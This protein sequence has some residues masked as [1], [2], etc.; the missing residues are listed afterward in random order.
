[1]HDQ[2]IVDPLAMAL[3]GVVRK[4]PAGER[5]TLLGVI[6]GQLRGMCGERAHP[7]GEVGDHDRDSQRQTASTC[8]VE[9]RPKRC[10]KRR[11]P[12]SGAA[13]TDMQ[14]CG[15]PHTSVALSDD[16]VLEEMRRCA[17]DL[18]DDFFHYEAYRSWALAQQV[19]NPD[20][21]TLPID[22]GDFIGRF[23]SYPRARI[24]AGL[25]RVPRRVVEDDVEGSFVACVSAIQAAADEIGRTR[26][27]STREYMQWRSAHL[28]DKERRRVLAPPP[29]WKTISDQF[30][31]WPNALAA[32]GI[33]SRREAADYYRGDGEHASDAHIARWL[34][35]ATT[36]LGQRVTT[37]TYTRWRDM[38]IDDPKAGYPP[39]QG[40]IQKR[41]G[42]W[43]AAMRTVEAA[44]EV[45]DPF[46]HIMAA[47]HPRSAT[48]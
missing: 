27:L 2:E 9:P 35:V 7:L 23:G 20:R 21:T 26:I 6:D 48:A 16:E 33:I 1:M 3:F 45:P 12:P 14:A 15:L 29:E 42:N 19:T 41:F 40:E 34:C 18:G 10:P 36:V 30:E 5:R 47:L 43:D 24:A 13:S 28:E 46:E 22:A 25:E 17:R 11:S 32:A 8:R 38:Q 44:R 37:G 31:T 4:L 39:G